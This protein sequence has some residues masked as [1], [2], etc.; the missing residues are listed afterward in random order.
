MITEA[1]GWEQ[2]PRYITGDRA[3]VYGN[4]LDLTQL[5]NDLLRR[6]PLTR[7]AILAPNV[8]RLSCHS[9]IT[10]KEALQHRSLAAPS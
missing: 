4:V 6:K 8:T 3:D 2:W 1:C 5:G 7:H 9:R 10:P